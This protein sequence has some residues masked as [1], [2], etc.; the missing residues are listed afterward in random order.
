M[1]KLVSTAMGQASKL[2]DDTDQKLSLVCQCP[3][4]V[5]ARPTVPQLEFVFS[6]DCLRVKSH[7]LCFITVCQ[8]DLN[9]FLMKHC[10]Y[11]SSTIF[12]FNNNKERSGH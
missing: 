3:M 12:V 6:F 11:A 7:F 8:F 9:V 1:F 4:L 2:N 10:I 5:F